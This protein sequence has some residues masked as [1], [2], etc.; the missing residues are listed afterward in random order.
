[1]LMFFTLINSKYLINKES[2]N[3]LETISALSVTASHEMNQPLQ[4]MLM[5]VELL[6]TSDECGEECMKRIGKIHECIDRIEAILNKMNNL[7]SIA[8]DDYTESEKM[9]DLDESSEID[10]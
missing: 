1:M 2:L 9:L 3:R 4:N 7:K 8:L 5:H 6:E 10:E